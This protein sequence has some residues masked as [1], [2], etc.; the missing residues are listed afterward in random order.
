MGC[1]QDARSDNVTSHV[2]VIVTVIANLSSDNDKP[3]VTRE[4]EMCNFLLSCDALQTNLLVS[5]IPLLQPST[6]LMS[7]PTTN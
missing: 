7:N 1:N 4:L 2:G 6:Q 5:N 3:V